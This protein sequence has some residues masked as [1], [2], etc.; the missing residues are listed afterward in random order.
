MHIHDPKDFTAGLLFIL[1]G[2]V[3]IVFVG[4]GDMGTLARMGPQYFPRI[5]GAGVLI[6]GAVVLLRSLR[7]GRSPNS[8]PIL[9]KLRRALLSARPLPPLLILG[10][11]GVFAVTLLPLGFIIATF[12]TIFVSTLAHPQFEWKTSVALGL[13]LTALVA[14]IFVGGMGLPVTL[15]PPSL[16]LI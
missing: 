11:A 15:L 6:I 5:M 1:I 2:L 14:A 12:I 13:F 9:R 4:E 10:S 16:N 3:A 7:F 8:E